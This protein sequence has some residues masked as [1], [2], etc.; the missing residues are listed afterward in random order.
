MVTYQPTSAATYARSR[1]HA[2]GSG[3]YQPILVF[4]LADQEYGI[5]VGDVQEVVPM[6]RLAQTP[7]QPAVLD[8]F[9]NLAGVVV[10]VVR[11]DRL[12]GLPGKPPN[13]YTPLLVLRHGTPRLAVRVDRV[14]RVLRPA[15]GDVVPVRPDE[16]FNGCVCG[17]SRTDG[18]VVLLLDPGRLLLDKEQQVLAEFQD[19]EQERLRALGGAVT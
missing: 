18:R 5:P 16:S 3:T 13:L 19:Q 9:L 1:P 6:A 7:F 10:P 11:L 17:V 12:L 8:G 14:D 2:L 4:A 15:E